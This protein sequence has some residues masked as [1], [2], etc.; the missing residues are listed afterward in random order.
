MKNKRYIALLMLVV[1]MFTMMT[2]CRQAQKYEDTGAEVPKIP[3][4]AQTITVT[5][6]G[7]DDET[8]STDTPM[9]QNTTVVE[10]TTSNNEA[11]TN[12]D[13]TTST[14]NT[15]TTDSGDED[16]AE[17][18]EKPISC[19]SFNV[20]NGYGNNKDYSDPALREKWVVEIVKD[21][22]P[23]IVGFQ[24]TGY[25]SISWKGEL[26]NDLCADGDYDMMVLDEQEDCKLDKNTTGAGLI[27]IWKA[28]RFELKDNGCHEYTQYSKQTRY[29]QW[30]KLYDKKYDK[31]VYVTNTHLS[32]DADSQK[33][34]K[35]AGIALRNSEAQ[36]LQAFWKKNVTGDAVLFA[37][38]DYNAK[39]SEAAHKTFQTGGTFMPSCELAWANDGKSFIDFVYTTP[40]TIEVDESFTIERTFKDKVDNQDLPATYYR[41][42]DHSPRMMRGFYK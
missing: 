18:E 4:T 11:T 35:D 24:E 30:V 17:G 27:I 29:F 12:T 41:A 21:N 15:T 6:T 40:A 23:D 2:G 9:D 38:G 13:A 8:S 3:G 22:D 7:I 39:Q 1:L 25:V 26:Y 19:M 42:S 10:D 20:L 31:T 37:T 34:D 5:Q 28:D 36:E 16:P 33:G 14:S 32:I